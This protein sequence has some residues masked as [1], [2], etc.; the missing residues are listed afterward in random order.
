MRWLK[1]RK[2]WLELPLRLYQLRKQ[3]SDAQ[4]QAQLDEVYDLLLGGDTSKAAE[5]LDSYP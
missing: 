5:I 3:Y 1:L 2:Q 4:A